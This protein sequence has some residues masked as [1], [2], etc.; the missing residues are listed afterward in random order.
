MPTALAPLATPLEPVIEQPCEAGRSGDAIIIGS[1]PDAPMLMIRPVSS[2]SERAVARA[3]DVRSDETIGRLGPLLQAVPSLLVAEEAAGKQLMEVVVNGSLVKAADGNGLRAFVMGPSGIEEHARLFEVGNL[4]NVVNAA[5]LWQVA[6]VLVAQKH[7]AD[8]S[9]KLT[10]IQKGMAGIS[11]FLD[12]QRKARIVGTYEYLGQV[13]AAL[14]RGELSQAARH[15]LESCERD[16]IEIQEHLMAEYRQ[17]ADA[18]VEVS[19]WGTKKTCKGIETKMDELDLLAQDIAVCLETRIAAWCV[20]SLLPGS[21]HQ[22]A[23]RKESI[24]ESLRAFAELG[25]Y[26]QDKVGIE[27]ANINSF[28]NRKA[29]LAL[30]RR[31]LERKNAAAAQ[32]LF[33][34][35]AHGL[36]QIRKSEQV[37]LDAGRTTH[38][39]L[40][41]EDGLVT[42]AEET[43]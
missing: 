42:G 31:S 25:P 8:I 27:I 40:S 1:S 35:S 37:M 10:Q 23:A 43:A 41:I 12:N 36:E 14:Q 19:P 22:K 28:W 4:Q 7:L 18:Q 9:S 32:S 26:G 29:T 15:E 21:P 34:L 38:L 13:Y 5:A 17:E 33:G 39:L 3:I 24:E 20:L 16:L 30:R 11:R 6:S 2:L